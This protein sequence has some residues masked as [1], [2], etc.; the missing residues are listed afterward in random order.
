[1]SYAYKDQMQSGNNRTE[2]ATDRDVQTSTSVKSGGVSIR[3]ETTC[4]TTALTLNTT[5]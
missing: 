5:E 4:F 2:R 1:M 3:L